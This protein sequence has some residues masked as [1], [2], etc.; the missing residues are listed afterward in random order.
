[1]FKIACLAAITLAISV[2]GAAADQTLVEQSMST[3][4]TGVWGCGSLDNLKQFGHLAATDTFLNSRYFASQHCEMLPSLT[5]VWV[6]KVSSDNAALCV[7]PDGESDCLWVPRTAIETMAQADKDRAD[8]A[9][10]EAKSKEIQDKG[11]AMFNK[12]HPECATWQTVKTL[13]DYCY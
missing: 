12:A 3:I 7:K 2:P 11:N 10:F 5:E 4:D 9:A 8:E 6:E 1:M 13:P